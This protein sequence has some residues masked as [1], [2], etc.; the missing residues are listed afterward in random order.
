MR[1]QRLGAGNATQRSLQGLTLGI[2]LLAAGSAPA[3]TLVFQV[4]TLLPGGDPYAATRDTEV[5]HA[6]P[7]LDLGAFE[8]VRSDFDS[9]GAEAQGLL[10][11]ANLFGSGPDRIPP[12]SIPFVIAD[13]P[14]TYVITDID[15][16]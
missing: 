8:S 5:D 2:V 7:N 12:G 14:G 16:R 9:F 3:E 11:F 13:Q 15:L 4:G 10:R 1:Q 6:R